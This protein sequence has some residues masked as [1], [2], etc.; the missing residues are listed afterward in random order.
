[1]P[2]GLNR[3][4]RNPT[5]V[6]VAGKT[7]AGPEASQ[8]RRKEAVQQ[9]GHG[10]GGRDARDDAAI[11]QPFQRNDTPVAC[12][13]CQGKHQP[14]NDEAPER[15]F[16]RIVQKENGSEPGR[17]WNHP[18]AESQHLQSAAQQQRAKMYKARHVRTHPVNAN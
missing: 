5:A 4:A 15:R 9:E 10:H 3:A 13:R 7:R 18:P 14:K 2:N 16:P 12:T 17:W 8:L 1:M 6:Q 11:A